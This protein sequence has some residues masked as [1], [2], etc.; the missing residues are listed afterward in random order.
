MNIITEILKDD[1]LILRNLLK[2]G[3]QE[4]DTILLKHKKNTGK[5]KKKIL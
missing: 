4:I 5:N 1:R 3:N 2:D